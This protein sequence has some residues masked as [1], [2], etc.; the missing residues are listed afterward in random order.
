[1]NW[2]LMSIGSLGIFGMIMTVIYSLADDQLSVDAGKKAIEMHSAQIES[3]LKDANSKIELVDE[4]NKRENKEIQEEISKWRKLNNYES[5]QREIHRATENEML[6]F[7]GSID[8]YNRKQSILDAADDKL[9]AVKESMD[10]DYEI[11]KFEKSIEEAKSLCKK[12]CRLYDIA[13]NDESVSEDV[14]SM[15]N[16]AKAVRDE[17]IKEAKDGI[18]ELKNK[19]ESESN[20]INREKQAELRDLEYEL[21]STRTRLN[22]QETEKSDALNKEYCDAKDAI[23]EQVIA[24]RTEEEI[25][26]LSDYDQYKERLNDQKIADAD[27]AMDI[28][29]NTPSHEKIASYL[30]SSH[31][32]RWFAG[33]VGTLPMIPAGYLFFSY[34]RFVYRTLRAM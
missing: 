17:T 22:K 30:K 10:Y 28:Y 34:G 31:C 16:K 13:A 7:K 15:K 21:Q 23:R 14:D 3:E 19:I 18:K 4:L 33:I 12:K 32:P 26:A 6:E 5:R 8:Y 25:A 1:M 27:Q 29:N 11:K 9:T 20:K 24:K 2:K